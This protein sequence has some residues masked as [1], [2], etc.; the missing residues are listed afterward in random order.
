MQK[1]GI[2]QDDLAQ[3]LGIS[4]RTLRVWRRERRGPGCE[5][6]DLRPWY[7]LTKLIPWLKKHRPDIDV[8]SSMERY[9]RARTAEKKQK[10][11]ADVWEEFFQEGERLHKKHQAYAEACRLND[12]GEHAKADRIL[13]AAGVAREEVE[14]RR[15]HIDGKAVNP[16]KVT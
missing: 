15:T 10:T 4:S 7:T 1:D 11:E 9:R 12:R 8:Q 6:D 16:T 3:L 5:F 2:S 13:L 14:Q